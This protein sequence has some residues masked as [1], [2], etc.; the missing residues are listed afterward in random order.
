[1]G[2]NYQ[3]WM[4]YESAWI[5]GYRKKMMRTTTHVTIPAVLVMLALLFG[6]LGFVDQMKMEDA[7]LGAVSG[8]ILGG[9]VCGF[10]YALLRFGLR[11]GKYRRLVERAVETADIPQEE[12]EQLGTELL[13]ARDDPKGR[14]YFEMKSLNSNN[15]PARFVLTPHYA[16]LVGGYPYA[17]LVRLQDIAEIRGG[18]EKKLE[19]RRGTQTRTTSLTTLYTIGYYRRDRADRSLGPDDLPDEAMGFFSQRVRDEALAMLAKQTGIV[20]TAEGGAYHGNV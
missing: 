1:M 20:R 14:I 11:D 19:T 15:T 16:M 5:A 17:I 6:G 18:E 12:R 4:E 13:A 2:P 3:G 7:I 8:L 9:V 10:F